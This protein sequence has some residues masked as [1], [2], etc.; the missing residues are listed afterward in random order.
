MSKRDY[1]QY[2]EHASSQVQTKLNNHVESRAK[3]KRKK[4]KNKNTNTSKN[5]K[6]SS[7]NSNSDSR[8]HHRSNG[9]KDI[10][11]KSSKHVGGISQKYTVS[12]K[13]ADENKK[14][15]VVSPPK[16]VNNKVK[17]LMDLNDEAL[18][19]KSQVVVDFQSV[20][21]LSMGAVHL[22][23][24]ILNVRK[25]PTKKFSG[26]EITGMVN[27][28]K[29]II[30][31]L[32]SSEPPKRT[33]Q[34]KG[35]LMTIKQILRPGEDAINFPINDHYCN[36]NEKGPVDKCLKLTDGS[37][38]RFTCVDGK[39]TSKKK[40]S[41]PIRDMNLTIFSNISVVNA[42]LIR[43]KKPNGPRIFISCRR[44]QPI[45]VCDTNMAWETFNKLTE[46]AAKNIGSQ[47]PLYKS[48]FDMCKTFILSTNIRSNIGPLIRSKNNPNGIPSRFTREDVNSMLSVKLTNEKKKPIAIYKIMFYN[49]IKKLLVDCTI[50]ITGQSYKNLGVVD[51]DKCSKLWSKNR[52]DIITAA[53]FPHGKTEKISRSYDLNNAGFSKLELQKTPSKI[54]AMVVTTCSFAFFDLYGKVQSGIKLTLENLCLYLKSRALVKKKDI[55]NIESK[56]EN[57]DSLYIKSGLSHEVYGSDGVDVGLVHINEAD[58]LN[59]Q[60]LVSKGWVFFLMIGSLDRGMDYHRGPL[61]NNEAVK[62]AINM[63]ILDDDDKVSSVWALHPGGLKETNKK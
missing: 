40:K 26:Y 45:S 18:E 47:I 56:I 34:H 51:A 58:G 13:L 24:Q 31:R 14:P 9:S 23:L 39:E 2:S 4:N 21:G 27:D 60:S 59:I 44:I 48:D 3:K 11:K 30:K 28:I 54:G 7:L 1:D 8:S 33:D 46:V 10:K 55:P 61:F 38:I 17:T 63:N 50:L 32:K 53:S 16:R 52:P 19:D 42:K 15:K 35:H 37:I 41:K 62:N 43:Q 6:H 12:E 29:S 20:A 36:I 5:K 49:W 25:I 57:E 22:K